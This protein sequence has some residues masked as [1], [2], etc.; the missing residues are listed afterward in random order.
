MGRGRYLRMT[1]HLNCKFRGS[2]IQGYLKDTSN[3]LIHN[4]LRSW[5]RE[6]DTD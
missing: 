1:I 6:L 2:E 4:K 5:S 3:I